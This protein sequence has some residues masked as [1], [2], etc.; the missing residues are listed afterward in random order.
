MNYDNYDNLKT[1]VYSRMLVIPKEH[2]LIEVESAFAGFAIYDALIFKYCTYNGL[3]SDNSEVCEH[4]YFNKSI[5]NSGKKIYI[6]PKLINANYTEHT[7]HLK[8]KSFNVLKMSKYGQIIININ[9][10]SLSDLTVRNNLISEDP[11]NLIIEL[12]KL[13]LQTQNNVTFYDIGASSGLY[14]LAV[15]KS[16]GDKVNIRSFESQRMVF[17]MLCGTVALNGYLNIYCY[18]LLISSQSTGLIKIDIP[19]HYSCTSFNDSIFSAP[20]VSN[21]YILSNSLQDYVSTSS[22]DSFNEKIDFIKINSNGMEEKIL[23]GVKDTTLQSRPIFFISINSCDLN[24]IFNYFKTANYACYQ[25]SIGLFTIPNEF[26]I[27]LIG[28]EKLF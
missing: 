17:N 16:F 18:N 1:A 13:R 9:K 22:I 20:E 28:I 11:L 24:F 25:N 5:L 8:N 23:L 15:A 19:N 7:N 4:V 2:D 26:E 10:K 12:L 14:S 6:N 3:N 27:N 21:D